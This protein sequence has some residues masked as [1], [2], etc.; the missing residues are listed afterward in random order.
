MIGYKSRILFCTDVNVMPNGIFFLGMMGKMQVE[1]LKDLCLKQ[2]EEI[3]ALKN[4]ILF[5]EDINSQLK[6][7]VEKQDSELKQAKHLIPTLQ[8][9]VTSLTGQL[10]CL[11]LD[12]AEVTSYTLY[13]LLATI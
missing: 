11:A 8:R 1:K 13:W 6:E 4:A 5:P 10:Q 7:V 9:Q 3:K 2:R 12:I